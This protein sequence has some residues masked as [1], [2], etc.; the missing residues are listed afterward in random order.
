MKQEIV[1]SEKKDFLNRYNPDGSIT[2]ALT[3]SISA[4]VQHNQLYSNSVTLI[5]RR[6]IREFWSK[7][8]L[9]L[10]EKYANT[11]CT[12]EVYE[13]EIISLKQT[14]NQQF[15]DRIDFRI[16]HA[17]K[18]ISVFFKHLWCMEKIETPPQC[19]V[20]RTILK[21]AG[22]GVNEQS[23]GY[24]DDINIHRQ[25]ISLIKAQSIRDGIKNIACWELKMF[26]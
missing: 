15:Q 2:N 21:R 12:E 22:A 24:I 13:S 23:W 18:S 16:S 10:F 19:P 20:D 3:K 25:K 1:F 7:K 6:N 26:N 11:M 8:L 17:Q 14:L 9:E 5:E 4:A